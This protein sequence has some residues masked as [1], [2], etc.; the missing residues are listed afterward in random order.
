MWSIEYSAPT[1]G[2]TDTGTGTLDL[3]DFATT[4]IPIMLF[5]MHIAVPVSELTVFSD[6]FLRKL[7]LLSYIEFLG[8]TPLLKLGRSW[9]TL[10]EFP[11]WKTDLDFYFFVQKYMYDGHINM[12]GIRIPVRLDPDLFKQIGILVRTMAVCATV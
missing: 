6:S 9:K 7:P 12:L 11:Q 10:R 2:I 1:A 8:G 3:A 4:R 5:F